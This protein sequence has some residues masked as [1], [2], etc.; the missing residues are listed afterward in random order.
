M[1]YKG[2]VMKIRKSLFV[3][4]VVIVL[5]S[6]AGCG[7]NQDAL[8]TQNQPTQETDNNL[9]PE[10]GSTESEP[11]PTAT[12][13]EPEFDAARAYLDTLEYFYQFIVS[14]STDFD[15]EYGTVGIGEQASFRTPDE[16]LE[17]T[18]FAII[19]LSGDGLPE[20]F[21]GEIAADSQ[22]VSLLA[23]AYA[24][25]ALQ[26]NE[27]ALTFTGWYRNAYF[28]HGDGRFYQTGSNGAMYSI[29]G[30]YKLSPDGLTLNCEHY[31]FTYEKDETL[32]EIGN[33]YNTSC[34]SDKAVSVELSDEELAE[35]RKELSSEP[36]SVELI[37]FAEYPQWKE[38]HGF[39]QIT[40]D[41]TN[42]LNA[43]RVDYASDEL[44]ANPG[45][46]DEVIIDAS[47]PLAKVVFTAN[48]TVE[49]FKY[50]EILLTDCVGDM[51]SF[52]IVEELYSINELRPE[53][54]LVIGM[55]FMGSI[56]NRGISFVDETGTTRYF[57][58]NQSGRDGSLFLL[59]FEYPQP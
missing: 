45:T 56:P 33:Y 59:E 52:D 41:T 39:G 22:A 42:L 40:T 2:K 6:L 1:T 32:S 16:A 3:L 9:S 13:A 23:P 34:Q 15:Y 24:V 38:E 54:P 29:E 35:K 10:P 18:G 21:I 17:S 4:I 11:E 43:I 8:Q 12:P 57:S 58:I 31:F 46:Y 50:L 44:L 25:F 53:R 49:D 28:Y 47:D 27:P 37:P 55:V 48:I 7:Q 5:I 51:C 19:D 30:I 26:D 14:G 36:V 20:L